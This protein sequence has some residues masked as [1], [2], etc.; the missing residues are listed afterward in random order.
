M[1]N[2]NPI[3]NQMTAV[4][5]FTVDPAIPDSETATAASNVVNTI[6]FRY[7][8]SQQISDLIESVALEQAALAAIAQ[9]EGAKIQKMA[10]MGGVTTQELLCLN[11][12]IADMMDSISMLEAVLKQ[13]LSIVDCQINGTDAGCM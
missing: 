5:T 6:V 1:P 13:K 11:K 3:A 9:A 8:F 10:A 7:N 2:P 4:F 12:S